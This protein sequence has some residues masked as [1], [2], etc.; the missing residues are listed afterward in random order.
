MPKVVIKSLYPT[1]QTYLTAR[2]NLRDEKGGHI[3]SSTNITQGFEI[4]AGEERKEQP[5]W[6]IKFD[7][8]RP[9]FFIEW[10]NNKE[11][12]PK[13]ELHRLKQQAAEL[14]CQHEQIQSLFGDT[15]KNLR[16]DPYYTIEYEGKRNTYLADLNIKKNAVFNKF[17]ELTPEEKRDCAF[18]Y[19]VPATGLRHSEL[20]TRMADFE[21]GHLMSTKVKSGEKLSP[22][23]H[24]LTLYGKD[25]VHEVRLMA[26]KSI[27]YGLISKNEKGYW[28]VQDF[29]GMNVQNVYDYITGSG[30]VKDTLKRE[31]ANKDGEVEN[32]LVHEKP[33]KA[34]IPVDSSKEVQALRDKA[35]LM[36]INYSN[37]M[38]EVK[39]KAA[40]EA[41]EKE[42]VV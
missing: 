8:Q 14:L 31:L 37:Q 42:L 2:I 16:G 40:I 18:Y 34:A 28:F 9:S 10:E 11:G 38:G 5:C 29:I 26:E 25:S 7:S 3:V 36:G 1:R 33:A 13:N 21:N 12:K 27:A 15:N 20:I 24:F 22:M 41:K 30:I 17:M 32:D 4:Y 35:K 6:K 39:L 19:V 23:E